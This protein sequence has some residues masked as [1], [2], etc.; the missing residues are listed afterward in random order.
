VRE[1][2]YYVAATADGFIARADG[3][4]DAFPFDAGYGSELLARYPETFP[5]PY[6]RQ[7]GNTAENRVFDAVLMGR[8][9]YEVGVREGLTSPYPT[10]DQYVV[11]TTMTGSPDPDVTLIAANAVDR[12][13]ELQYRP[14]K[15]IWLCGG[16]A[17]ASSLLSAGLLSGLILK[18]NPVVFGSGVPLFRGEVAPA[19][20]TLTDQQAFPSGHLLL[21]YRVG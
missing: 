4:F 7:I 15:A 3:S 14:G 11:S 8:A 12:I 17:L 10:L 16:G 20:L 5:A 9:T 13:R 21:Q 2:I 18:L 6:R 1:I 19:A